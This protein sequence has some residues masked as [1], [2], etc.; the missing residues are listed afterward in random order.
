MAQGADS[1]PARS[2]PSPARRRVRA[3]AVIAIAL[4]AGFVVWFL[5]RDSGPSS[6][7][8]APRATAV[9]V[10]VDGLATLA[11]AVGRPIYWAGERAGFT[12][13]LTK[14]A[15]ERVYIRYLPQGVS[16]GTDDPYLTVGTYAV[17]E[18]Y[19]ATKKVAREGNSVRVP[20]GRS[21]VAFYSRDS[22]TNVYLAYRGSDY[23]VEVYSPAATQAQQLVAS[24]RI[25]PVSPGGEG[26]VAPT[27]AESVSPA[28]MKDLAASLEH[29]LYWIGPKRNKTYEL[30]TTQGGNVYLRYLPA[31]V[32]TGSEE[33]YTM[34]GTYPVENG[35]SVT[36]SLS[37]KPGAVPIPIQGDGVAFYDEDLPTNVYLAYR[38]AELQVEVFD[39]SAKRAQRLVASNRIVPVG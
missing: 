24:G 12:Y 32:E 9:P 21:G 39:P 11:G 6:D 8:S 22:P 37:R 26:T 33:Q 17:T 34:I 15:D 28:E 4:V 29:D 35:F 20:I 1:H 18:A 13:E 10:T 36:R 25:R 2:A 27:A 38:G 7:V 19:A 16:V 14:T 5:L 30:T 23:Q 31:G 3:G